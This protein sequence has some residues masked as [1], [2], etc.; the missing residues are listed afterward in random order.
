MPAVVD[1]E[2]CDGCGT[3]QTNCPTDAIA[4]ENGKAQVKPDDCID[5]NLCEGNCEQKAIEMK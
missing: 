1:Q 4:L 2:K 3:C 5:C